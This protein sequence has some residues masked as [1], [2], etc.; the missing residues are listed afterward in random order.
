MFARVG[1]EFKQERVVRQLNPPSMYD[2]SFSSH[3]A[4]CPVAIFPRAVSFVC[5]WADR[6]LCIAIIGCVVNRFR[7]ISGCG[8]FPA[9]QQPS[10][11]D[12]SAVVGLLR[13]G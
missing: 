3:P 13:S 7:D 5:K 8:G 1:L 9:V 12:T 2:L 4:L 11:P 6:M 10:Y